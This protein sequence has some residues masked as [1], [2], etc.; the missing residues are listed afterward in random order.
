MAV[1]LSNLLPPTR[2]GRTLFISSTLLGAFALVQMALLGWYLL[3]SSGRP[4]EASLIHFAE[5]TEPTIDIP[6]HHRPVAAESTNFP[7]ATAPPAAA[8]SAPLPTP[9][10]PRLDQPVPATADHSSVDGLI[11]H[12]RRLRVNGDATTAL[13]ELRQAQLADPSDPQIIAELGITYEAMQLPD[14][15]FEQWRLLY[16]MGDAVGALYYLADQ[17][18]HSAPA[19]PPPGTALMAPREAAAA[20]DTAG[21]AADSGSAT[22]N[23]ML[24]ITDI[25]AEDKDDPAVGRKVALKIVVKN[26]PGTVIN[27]K[28]VKIETYFYDLVDGRDVVQTNAQTGYAW[29][30][31]PVSWDH[32]RSEVLETTYFRAK[33]EPTPTPAAS[34]TP[35]EAAHGAKH[36]RKG[37]AHAAEASPA[38]TP[39][40][41]PAQVRTYLGYTVLLYYEGQLQDVKAD[42]LRLLQ[43]FPPR[44]TLPD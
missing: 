43:Q 16:N 6:F 34:A 35:D 21:T 19:S 41:A 18:L 27:P 32:D 37:K 38:A 23:V 29:L 4:T 24:K 1:S 42:P 20:P 10:A 2:S 31:A 28:K 17:K 25:S 40:P 3:R 22:D 12:A 33:E 14:R 39:T 7:A 8:Q 13:A 36:G 9:A 15:A 44:L 26:R 11:E 30:T 5:T